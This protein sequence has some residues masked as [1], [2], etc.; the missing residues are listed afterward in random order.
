MAPID[1]DKVRVH[2][3]GTLEDG[4]MF[5]SSEGRDPLE[6]VVGSGDVIPGFDA[7]VRELEVGQAKTFTIPSCEAY[8]DH[9]PQAVRSVPREMFAQEPEVGWAVELQAEDGT[10]LAAVIT[11]IGEEECVL[12]FNHPLAGKDLTFAV[13]LVEIVDD[14][15]KLIIP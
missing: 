2:Y 8:G 15:P 13:E 7:A 4:T 9:D 3:T 5:D 11:E 6:F 14:T 1:G 10:R 12:D